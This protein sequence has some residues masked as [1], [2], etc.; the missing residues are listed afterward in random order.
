[1][2]DFDTLLRETLTGLAD[3]APSEAGVRAALLRRRQRR[4]GL[5][6][7]AIAATLA[8]VAVPLL[9]VGGEGGAPPTRI[10][11]AQARTWAY[12][13]TPSWLPDGIT[14]Q[15]RVAV[16]AGV[17]ARLLTRTWHTGP[18]DL[19]T[20]P[21]LTLSVGGTGHEFGAGVGSPLADSGLL[22][23]ARY[24]DTNGVIGVR[25]R[26]DGMTVEVVSPFRFIDRAAMERI[27]AGLRP[28]RGPLLSAALST[29]D[30]EVTATGVRAAPDGRPISFIQ[31]SE[32]E[33][34]EDPEDSVVVEVTP[35]APDLSRPDLQLTVLGRE[36]FVLTGRS[37]KGMTPTETLAIPV[38]G[39]WLLVHNYGS[40]PDLARVAGLVDVAE[41]VRIG[42]D[43]ANP[44][45]GGRV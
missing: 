11:V 8:V 7:A 13:L 16:D 34:P 5:I 29:D 21:A 10:P 28:T 30:G 43:P 15:Q 32:P 1:M 45:L 17:E 26:Y 2:T 37:L 22:E 4:A 25:G 27:A 33:D 14:E 9:R 6:A 24:Y 44:W 31:L 19:E 23:S 36:S 20:R 41:K 18:V 42:P 12:P 3:R 40:S 39:R 35:L 38:E